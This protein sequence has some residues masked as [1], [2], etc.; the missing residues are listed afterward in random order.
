MEVPIDAQPINLASIPLPN[1]FKALKSQNDP[2]RLI[3]KERM[4]GRI[5]LDE[6][7][8]LG[9]LIPGGSLLG[10]R[11]YRAEGRLLGI[12]WSSQQLT[13][14]NLLLVSSPASP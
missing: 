2:T 11:T 5:A 3:G 9:E 4:T 10:L 6:E 7:N 14:S 1:P 8:N 13:V 12:A